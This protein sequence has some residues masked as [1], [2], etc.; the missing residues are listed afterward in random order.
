MAQLLGSIV[1]TL[2]LKFKIPQSKMEE[3]TRK[4]SI[5]KKRLSVRELD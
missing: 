2:N 3:A 5:L 1:Y 4:N